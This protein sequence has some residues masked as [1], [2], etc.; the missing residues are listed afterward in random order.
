MKNKIMMKHL[1]VMETNIVPNKA[2]YAKHW[3]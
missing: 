1:F 2:N 3:P